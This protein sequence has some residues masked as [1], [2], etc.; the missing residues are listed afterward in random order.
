MP[1]EL[2]P[3][4]TAPAMLR[5]VLLPLIVAIGASFSVPFGEAALANN[6]FQH[7]EVEAMS[8]SKQT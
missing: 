8:A 7:V 2:H 4:V 1:Q 6:S 5:P 3:L